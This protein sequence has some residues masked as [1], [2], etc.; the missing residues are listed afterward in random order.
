MQSYWKARLVLAIKRSFGTVNHPTNSS[1]QEITDREVNTISSN[2][3]ISC[4]TDAEFRARFVDEIF[5][6]FG[7]TYLPMRTNDGMS[8]DEVS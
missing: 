7:W 8:T 4:D 1:R 6:H 2:L 3:N 5:Q